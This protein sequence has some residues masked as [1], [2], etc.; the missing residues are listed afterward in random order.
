[1]QHNDK[2]MSKLLRTPETARALELAKAKNTWSFVRSG[3]FIDGIE[4][5]LA[6]SLGAYG[7]RLKS[8]FILI[9][10]NQVTEALKK[11]GPEGWKLRFD[12]HF[13][14][15]LANFKAEL[16]KLG[17]WNVELKSG[18]PDI[19]FHICLS[20]DEDHDAAEDLE[21][22]RTDLP[23]VQQLFREMN[24]K[25]LRRLTAEKRDSSDRVGL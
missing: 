5:Q 15:L 2:V 21:K 8:E 9:Q 16:N 10:D 7:A 12:L 20:S 19:A 17:Y 11:S 3:G 13:K 22:I 23:K 6:L 1:M 14:R 18:H 4:F 24:A 25:A